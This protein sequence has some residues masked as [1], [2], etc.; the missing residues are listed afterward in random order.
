MNLVQKKNFDYLLVT[1]L[2]SLSLLGGCQSSPTL[3]DSPTTVE[4]KEFLGLTRPLLLEL[5]PSSYKEMKTAYLSRVKLQN[6][7]GP[8]LVREN[9][10]KTEFVVST[11]FNQRLQDRRILE[12]LETTV[13]KSGRESLSTFGLPEYGEVLVREYKP[14]GDIVK[15]GR[16][17]MDSFFMISSFVF[18]ETEVKVGDKWFYKKSWKA[19]AEEFGLNANMHLLKF[20][21]CLKD[22]VCAR[23]N[24]LAQVKEATQSKTEAGTLHYGQYLFAVKAGVVLASQFLS[25]EARTQGKRSQ[26]VFTCLSSKWIEA[27][28]QKQ[29]SAPTSCRLGEGVL[30]EVNFP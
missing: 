8:D 19:G 22:D 21:P 15:A 25:Q 14:N 4:K 16:Y 7:E 27:G 13:Q 24:V 10:S 11:S 17:N 30:P 2:L 18:P 6:Y 5:K 29:S 9:E 26:K 12:V 28:G 20:E 1:C 23:V 3:G